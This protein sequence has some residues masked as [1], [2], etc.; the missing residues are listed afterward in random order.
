MN[1]YEQWRNRHIGSDN[2]TLECLVDLYFAI[3]QHLASP[4]SHACRSVL[5]SAVSCTDRWIQEQYKL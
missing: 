3:T 2:P 1:N 5:D 4:S